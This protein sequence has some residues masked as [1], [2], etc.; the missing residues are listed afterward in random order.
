MTGERRKEGGSYNHLLRFLRQA[1]ALDHLD[2]LE[3][4]D[5]V[6]LH[7]V[8]DF[9]AEGGALLDGEGVFLQAFEL[10]GCRAVDYDVWSPFALRV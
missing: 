4:G 7:P 5:D 9:H 2:V 6:V 1:H 8:L 10:G 3:P